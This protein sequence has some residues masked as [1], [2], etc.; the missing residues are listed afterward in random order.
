M[1][2]DQGQVIDRAIIQMATSLKLET[3]DEGIEH[4]EEAAQL[5][6]VGCHVGQEH[7]W[8]EPQSET[9]IMGYLHSFTIR[10]K[11]SDDRRESY[12]MLWPSP[13]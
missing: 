3:V 4:E 13:S 5:R 7:E 8:T 2:A 11:P 9:D 6:E 1:E 10:T 12:A